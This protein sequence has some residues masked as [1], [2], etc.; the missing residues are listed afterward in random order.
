MTR[1]LKDL[2]DEAIKI[3]KESYV[4]LLHLTLCDKASI[5]VCLEKLKKHHN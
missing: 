2:S 5:F 1:V 3:Q 4:A